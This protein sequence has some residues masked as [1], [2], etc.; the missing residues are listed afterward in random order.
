M[1]YSLHPEPINQ[2]MGGEM[3]EDEQTALMIFLEQHEDFFSANPGSKEAMLASI[4]NGSVICRIPA[5]NSNLKKDLV[6]KVNYT[7]EPGLKL[8][9]YADPNVILQRALEPLKDGLFR[10]V[11]R[12]PWD[13][14]HNQRKADSAVIA[15]MRRGELVHTIDMS[16]A[17][18]NFPWEYQKHV[19]RMVTNSRDENTRELVCLMI[20][21]VERGMFQLSS[22]RSIR[23]C[24]W[25]KGQPLGLGPSF[26]LFTLTH[27]LVLYALNEGNW[28]GDF[29]V[30]GDDVIILNDGLA[31]RYKKWLH[32]VGVPISQA[33]SFSSSRIGQFAGKT[34]TPQGA[35]WTPKW[36]E[37]TQDNVLD[38][39]AWWFPGLSRYFSKDRKTIDRVLS[40][41]Q[42]YGNGWNPE[43]LSLDERLSDQMVLNILEREDERLV[44]ARPTST[45]VSLE[46]LRAAMRARGF[47]DDTVLSAL[48]LSLERDRAISYPTRVESSVPSLA[49]SP[50]TEVPGYPSVRFN[51]RRVDPYSFGMLSYWK[52][53]MKVAT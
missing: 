16:K 24:R 4:D 32:D 30:L 39:C 12:V 53:I 40:L 36:Q 47:N 43:G 46:P 3:L 34:F 13:C 21:L 31:A 23:R 41:P 38:C 37:V 35:F 29:Y 15:G 14:T 27:G 7:F 49:Y 25:N 52:S 18:D 11:K 6:G 17:T 51:E 44:K 9:F 26:P 8:R 48:H 19:L 50:G 28:S 5:T 1:P 42:P 22:G 10:I 45:K 33:K 20:S 2:A